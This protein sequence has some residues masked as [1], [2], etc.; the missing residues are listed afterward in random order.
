MIRSRNH[1]H[2]I[3]RRHDFSRGIQERGIDQQWKPRDVSFDLKLRKLFSK[4]V[5]LTQFEPPKKKHWG[6]L[7][8]GYTGWFFFGG[9]PINPHGLGRIHNPL[10]YPQQPRFLLLNSQKFIRPKKTGKQHVPSWVGI[11]VPNVEHRMDTSWFPW[12]HH[13]DHISVQGHV[14]R[15]HQH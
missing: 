14:Y 2:F 12:N 1:T 6:S 3:Q 9:I 11:I 4:K 13:G 10:I 7:T 15:Y 5:E 8:F